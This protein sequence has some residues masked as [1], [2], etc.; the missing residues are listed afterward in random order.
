[1]DGSVFHVDLA[2][3]DEAASG[4]ART[5]A[6]HD[7]SGLSDLEQPAAGYGDDDMAGAF[8]EFCDRWNSGLDLLTEDARLISEVLAR[9]AS[10]YRETDEVAA[11]SLTVDPALGAVDD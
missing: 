8:H 11:A 7:R 1:M 4:I 3:M 2:A 5:V 10:V 9:A 6:D